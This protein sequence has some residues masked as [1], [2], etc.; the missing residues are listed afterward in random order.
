[1]LLTADTLTLTSS[2]IGAV[3]AA[4]TI[5][6]SS[7]S[8]CNN[9]FGFIWNSILVIFYR[10]FTYLFI[11]LLCKKAQAIKTSQKS[12]VLVVRLLDLKTRRLSYAHNSHNQI[13]KH[14]GKNT[15]GLGNNEKAS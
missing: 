13:K 3:L 15:L 4:H 6:V 5:Q 9:S 12:F 2:W 7:Y 8:N 11:T 14:A 10:I 1:M